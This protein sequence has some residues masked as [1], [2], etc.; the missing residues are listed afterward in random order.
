MEL[1]APT[2]SAQRLVRHAI[3]FR[4]GESPRHSRCCECRLGV[5]SLVH[6]L[7][8]IAVEVG[9][10][11]GVVAR[12]EVGAIDWSALVGAPALIAAA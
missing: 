2:I 12:G 4:G 9:D 3:A 8:T 6:E 7:N 5:P 1:G 11:G 10:V